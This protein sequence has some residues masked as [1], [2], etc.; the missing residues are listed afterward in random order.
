M[1][2]YRRIFYRELNETEYNQIFQDI[3]AQH[4]IREYQDLLYRVSEE[5]A[6]YL[7]QRNN[8]NLLVPGDEVTRI[9]SELK[10][11]YEPYPYCIAPNPECRRSLR[12]GKE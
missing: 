12:H 11:S 3:S 9:I 8:E 7:Y 4:S 5:I 1:A 6:W 10:L 2:V